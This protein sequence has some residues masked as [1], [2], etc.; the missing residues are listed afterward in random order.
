MTA[1]Q[2]TTVVPVQSSAAPGLSPESA[3]PVARVA[4]RIGKIVRAEV[5]RS[6]WLTGEVIDLRRGRGGMLRFE[7]RDQNTR[8]ACVM[9]APAQTHAAA[10]ENGMR[11]AVLASLDVEAWNGRLCLGVADARD[12][13][14]GAEQRRL[15]RL[16]ERLRQQGL[17]E[18]RRKRPVPAHPSVVALI[19]SLSGAARHDFIAVARR[20]HPGVSVVVIPATM[21]G[22]LAVAS[23]VTAL[24]QA[25]R[26]AAEVVVVA[27][28]GG[29]PADLTVFS[30]EDLVLAI[31]GSRLPVV[32]AIG[33]ET[34]TPLVDEVADLRTGTPS[35][36]A[37][38]IIPDRAVLL[39]ALDSRSTAARQRLVSRVKQSRSH[40]DACRGRLGHLL[41]TR[42]ARH[43]V[44]VATAHDR[45]RAHVMTRCLRGRT[46]L[47]RRRELTTQAVVYRL[48]QERARLG[49]LSAALEALNPRAVLSRGYAFL[50]NEQ[51]KVVSSIA[52]LHG[53]SAFTLRMHD[54]ELTVV[55]ASTPRNS[56]DEV[57]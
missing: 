46:L 4:I 36:A 37:E 19:T 10:L 8:I 55:V 40:L 28:G 32:T 48:R 30:D 5:K 44:R 25:N 2:S 11:V 13:G 27:R 6:Y 45:L 41:S 49:R 38:R 15:A 18:I 51:G 39:R 42:A 53:G 34:D 57:M 50:T 35:T 54:G 7:L 3:I 1:S 29:S 20:R 31:A 33:H 24:A 23:I 16:R 17:F 43:R 21:Q 56:L 9:S 52:G 22:T 26:T 47:D 12:Q 14:A